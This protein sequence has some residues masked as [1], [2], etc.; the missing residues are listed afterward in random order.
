MLYGASIILPSEY[1]N[2][3]DTLRAVERYESTGLFG[4][5]TMFV[6]ML[7]HEKLSTTKRSSL[8]LGRTKNLRNE[9]QTDPMVDSASYLDRLCQTASSPALR[10]DF[11]SETFTPTGA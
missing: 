2:T 3:E 5:T 1:F 10:R 7:S 6:D 11:P 8:R 9:A 4:V